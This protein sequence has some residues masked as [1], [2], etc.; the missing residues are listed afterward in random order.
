MID[1]SNCSCRK[2]IAAAVAELQATTSSF[3]SR[4]SRCEAICQANPESSMD[5]GP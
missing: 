5:L 4:D 3:T 2:V 1:A